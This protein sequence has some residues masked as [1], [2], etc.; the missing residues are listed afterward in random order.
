MAKKKQLIERDTSVNIYPITHAK[1]VL[2]EDGTTVNS[3][4][5]ELY[6]KNDSLVNSH[7]Q[8]VNSIADTNDVLSAHKKDKDVKHIPA[9]GKEK[10][11][12]FWRA[13]GRAGW[14]NLTEVFP[15]LE[16]VLS[17][18]VEWDTSIPDPQLSR[19]GNMLLHK[20][21]PIQSQLRG[22]IAQGDKIIY[23]LDENDWNYKK[24][25]VYVNEPQFEV[26][27]TLQ[28]TFDV[29]SQSVEC[30]VG[31]KVRIF[32]DAMIPVDEGI[33]SEITDG[34]AHITWNEGTF[35]T[36]GKVELGARLDGYDGTVRV[37]CPSFYIKST[38]KGNKRRVMISSHKIDDTW[39]YQPEVLIDAYKSTIITKVP[40]GMGYIS[41]L[42]SGSA[43]SIVN[44][45]E[46]C[47]GG[48]N[49]SNYDTYL[50]STPYRSDLGKPRI[51]LRR[52]QTREAA[53]K[54]KSEM[55]SYEQ[56][57]NIFY[58]LYVIEYA[59][60][61]SQ[62]AYNQELTNEGYKQGGLGSGVTTIDQNHWTYYN[63]DCPLVPC[64]Y[65]NSLG[66]RTGI[67]DLTII[68]PITSGGDPSQ[69]Y[70]FQ[71]PRWRGF[72]N[73]FGDTWTN[74]DGIIVK[75]DTSGLP[76]NVYATTDSNK[77]GDDETA[78]E[79]MKL[80]GNEIS[81]DGFIKE[82]N[83]GDA[84]HIIPISVGG[85]TTKYKCDYHYTGA[86]D[87]SLRTFMV[88]GS[89]TNNVRA[90]LGDINSYDVVGTQ[91]TAISF[92]TVSR[93]VINIYPLTIE[94]NQP[95]MNIVYNLG[96]ASNANYMTYEEAEAVT[97]NDLNSIITE[98]KNSS[99]NVSFDEFKYFTSISNI[100]TSQFKD[101][102]KLVSITIPN[103]VTSIDSTAFTGCNALNSVTIGTQ[104]T[105][106]G[107]SA[108]YNCP[109][110]TSVIFNAENCTT[111]GSSQ[112]YPVFDGC[113]NLTS[114]TIG[115]KVKTIPDMAFQGCT[116]LTSV[117][118]GNSVTKIGDSAFLHCTALTS[119]TIPNS[120]TSIEMYAFSGSGLTSVTIPNSVTSIGNYAFGQCSGLT[121]VT[122]GNSVTSI[123]SRAF[124]YCS[125]LASVTIPNSITS[126]D[127]DAFYGTA[128]YNNQPDGLVYAGKVAYSY[129]GT[130]PENTSIILKD[131][132]VSISG[133]A[134]R[135]KYNLLSITIP[136][137]VNSIGA[138]ALQY[139]SSLEELVIG[140][141][142]TYIG[143]NAFES[144]NKLTEVIIPDSVTYLGTEAFRS[145]SEL[146]SVTIGN[147]LTTINEDVFDYC[148]KLTSVI[149]GQS[150][151]TI[152]RDAFNYCHALTSIN[153]PESVTTIGDT[154]FYYC[155]S[156]TSI[157]LPDSLTYIGGSAFGNCSKLTQ[158]TIPESV[159]YIG[160]GAF[161]G[162]GALTSIVVDSGNTSYD[163]RDNCNAII[164]TSTNR[165]LT[166]CKN[167][168]IPS[169]VTSIGYGVFKGCTGLT[170]I[171]I[172]NLVTTIGSSA[173][174]GCTGLTSIV[175]PDSI[176][177]IDEHTF[178]DCSALTSINI[179][180]SVTMIGNNAFEDC[181]SLTSITIPNSV[182]T[183]GR[184]AFY[185]CTKLVEITLPESVET[186][187]SYAFQN[188][189]ALTSINIPNKV[190]ILNE[191]IFEDCDS[192]T[193][194]II[195]ESVVE[196]RGQALAC[197][198]LSTITVKATTAPTVYEYTFGW[199][200]YEY[201]GRNTYDKGT[202]I[203]YVPSG[204]TGYESGYWK[205][206]LLDST[207]CGFTINYIS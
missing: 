85:D 142:V 52:N 207:K 31:Q 76:K 143:S 49:R 37:Y 201:T 157:T 77:Y 181:H 109:N 55:L 4:I 114:I 90:G 16:E 150:V 110:L 3:N 17:Y 183:I 128:W 206:I 74:L 102:N 80:I 81:S 141:Q 8:L 101:C 15:E 123:G 198:N 170:S 156:L 132:T 178:E 29:A 202:N 46:Y 113:F 172:P 186:I 205:S 155:D 115:N 193:S 168:V 88:G 53:R 133:G 33:I 145:C 92:R 127:E 57:K 111:M 7:N 199:S 131:G 117:T 112:Q 23:W 48:N 129:K 149:L 38:S 154:A 5:I 75:G 182:T 54:A 105:S 91:N 190:T 160:S 63:E 165:L 94:S 21:L 14:K 9:G 100:S 70:T 158:I 34:V 125:G 153:I 99:V 83:L 87:T 13:S 176:T 152:E 50:T 130:M 19:V 166:G 22:C 79:A 60:F 98:I 59:N 6:S 138:K 24:D 164:E 58:W 108:F 118:I 66:N 177:T 18:G 195:P 140:N 82:F 173:F 39:T 47:R 95:L 194:L 196:I 97:D 25:P 104:V 84:A 146:T 124:A 30:F 144:C 189:S 122:I 42:P 64:G 187:E 106:I 184:Y 204:A 32:D 180:E 159:T 139:C 72:D 107:N 188:C 36:G 89:A 175:L 45:S 78:L 2:L 65:G 40:N 136:N 163:S 51:Q 56:Y 197:T 135:S 185:Y 20:T 120:V 71:V 27:G 167:T 41:T 12:L 43:V 93:E 134:F 137:T 68:T 148:S 119:V 161:S 103:S 116:A 26:I 126:V 171:T 191:G 1:C 62:E 174:Q 192:L 67:K 147:S 86:N 200:D 151:T 10:Q 203:L 44:T 61:N 35:D 28:K 162:C 169:T 179:P 73:P 11:L 69:S 96:L 121:S